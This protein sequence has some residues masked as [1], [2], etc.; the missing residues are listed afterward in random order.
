MPLVS[1]LIPVI[2][3]EWLNQAIRSA[4][5]QTCKDIE[6]IISDDTPGDSVEKVVSVWR[7]ARIKYFKNPKQGQSG[8]NRD[9]IISLAQGEY[10][11][12][13]FDDD[14]LYPHS[15]EM[16]LA[17]LRGTPF[18]LAFHSRDVVNSD[19][20]IIGRPR[21]R[22]EDG[23]G[24]IKKLQRKS[25]QLLERLLPFR[26]STYSQK[27]F[28]TVSPEYFYANMIAQLAN[29]VGEPTNI[30]FHSETFRGM[31]DPY[32]VNGVPMRFLSDVA[33]YATF[34][35]AGHGIIGTSKVASAYRKHDQQ[36]SNES[37]PRFSAGLFEWEVNARH[38]CDLG[39]LSLD[40][41]SG[42]RERLLALYQQYVQAFPE[43]QVFIDLPPVTPGM[44]SLDEPTRLAVRYAHELIDQRIAERRLKPKS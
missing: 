30:M 36:T 22:I 20:Q 17:M 13:L 25:T 1:I 23:N 15:V 37:S 40:Q 3:T 28:L 31:A 6:I 33:L 4:V 21:F 43:L 27:D 38:A 29:H 9:Y 41:L 5:N 39:Y 2:R 11:K 8:T 35:N 7:D 18:K 12:H 26:H 10:I 24:L 14:F 32:S 44:L 34:V 19:G 42:L 16:L